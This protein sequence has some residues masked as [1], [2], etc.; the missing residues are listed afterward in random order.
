MVCQDENLET[1][2]CGGSGEP[3]REEAMRS[4]RRAPYLVAVTSHTRAPNRTP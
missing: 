1:S 2:T 3:R 4:L